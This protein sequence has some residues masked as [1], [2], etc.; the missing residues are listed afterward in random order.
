MVSGTRARVGAIGVLLFVSLLLIRGLA[1]TP[2][3]ASGADLRALC[4]F[5]RWKVKTFS[6]ADR[7]KVSLTPHY[8]T[9]K[10]LNALVRPSP[11]PQNGR[12]AGELSVYRITATVTATINED[13]GDIHLA[14][15]GADGTTL[16]AEAPGPGCD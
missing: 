14:L 5:E 4:G 12:V 7:S 2:L 10:H 11:R 6:D 1:T 13:D 9:T 16:I 8:R 3:P 15:I